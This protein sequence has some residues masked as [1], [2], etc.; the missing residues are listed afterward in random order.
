MGSCG[1]QLRAVSLKFGTIGQ[2]LKLVQ[3]DGRRFTYAVRSSLAITRLPGILSKST[4]RLQA[5]RLVTAAKG[6]DS[7]PVSGICRPE[8]FCANDLTV[9]A[10]CSRDAAAGNRFA[11]LA[12][13]WIRSICVLPLSER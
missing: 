5:R 12:A 7:S 2:G 3:G 9:A 1:M 13:K 4:A 6:E 10:A 8:W 11:L